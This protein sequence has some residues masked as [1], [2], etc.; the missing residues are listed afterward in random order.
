MDGDFYF[1]ILEFLLKNE[2]KKNTTKISYKK[3]SSQI[4][5]FGRIFVL[6]SG[7]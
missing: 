5:I 7:S 4:N 1:W 3:E 2:K 6:F